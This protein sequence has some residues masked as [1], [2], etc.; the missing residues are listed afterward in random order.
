MT[1][2][3][4]SSPRGSAD[5]LSAGIRRAKVGATLVALLCLPAAGPIASPVRVDELIRTARQ[6][7]QN[8]KRGAVLYREHCA[9]CHGSGALGDAKNVI[10]SLAGQRQAHLIKQLADFT[11][12]QRDI[13]D[14]HRVVAN[15]ALAE[16]QA[17]A[18]ITGYLNALPVGRFPATGDGTGV[19]LGEAIF[20]EQCSSCHEEDARG[21]DDGFVPSLRNQHY[22]YLVRQT[23]SMGSWH[24]LN[25]DADLVRF[26]D[27]MQTNEL[28]AVADYLSRLRG[29]TKDRVKLHN[30]GTVGD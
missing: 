6:L 4:H 14:M 23:R 21:D 26:L 12:L 2:Q 15:P 7:D 13:R 1:T 28:T 9:S 19:E 8:A 25:V 27:R 11:E 24:R 18:N 10:P 17:W 30:D 3:A 16:P 22:S 5:A 29:P 20:Q